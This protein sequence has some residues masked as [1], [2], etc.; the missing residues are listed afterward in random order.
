MGHPIAPTEFPKRRSAVEAAKK[1]ASRSQS[2]AYALPVE[3]T[4]PQSTP[5]GGYWL[6]PTPKDLAWVM[7]SSQSPTDPKCARWRAPTGLRLPC[8]SAGPGRRQLKQKT[9]APACNKHQRYA[10]C[11]SVGRAGRWAA[12][13][14]P[15]PAAVPNAQRAGTRP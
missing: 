3:G 13:A 9:A 15:R 14:A 10:T 8:A 2:T 7:A 12:V 5:E 4:R 1:L 6:E 11:T